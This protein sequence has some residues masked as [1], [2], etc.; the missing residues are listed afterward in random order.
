M[1]KRNLIL[2]SLGILLFV[3]HAVNSA[4]RQFSVF[5]SVPIKNEL[6]DHVKKIVIRELQELPD[7]KLEDNLS[8]EEGHYVISII[9]EPIKLPNRVAIGV[10]ISY[11]FQDSQQIAHGL[12]TG[13]P[14]DLENLCEQLVPMFDFKFIEPNRRK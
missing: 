2:A 9:A 6:T 14:E 12:L 13:S 1:K 3:C 8:L 4:D 11:V 5:V 10:A 7:I